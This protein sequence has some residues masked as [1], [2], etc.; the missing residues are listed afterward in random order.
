MK[1]KMVRI[2]DEQMKVLQH[3]SDVTGV[4]IATAVHEALEDF[5]AAVV[6]ARLKAFERSKK[7][8]IV[9]I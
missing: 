5:I 8:R 7:P 4:P 9:K 6:P 3:Y 1:Q 2:E